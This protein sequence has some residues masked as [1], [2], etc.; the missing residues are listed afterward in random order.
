M[1]RY[2]ALEEIDSILLSGA[3]AALVGCLEDD[4]LECK[5]A[6]YDLDVER[7]KM[8]LAKDVSALANSD[9]GIVLIGV[10][11]E[12]DPTYKSDIIR[13]VSCFT[14]DLVDLGRYRD[15]I[16]DWVI[17]SIPGL[18]FEWHADST[19]RNEGI[20]SIRVPKEACSDRP[21]VVAKAVGDVGGTLGSYLGYFERTRETV[22]PIK[23]AELRDRLRDGRRFSELDRRLGNIEETVGKLAAGQSAQEPPFTAEAVFRR[24]ERARAQAGL[25]GAPCLSFA[26]WPLQPIE[27]PN[28]FGSHQV[29]VV[30]VLEY[31]P[32]LREAGFNI[33]TRRPSDI[34][35]ARL[36]RCLLP[37]RVLEV[38]RDGPVICVLPGGDWHLCWGMRSSEHPG[39]WI[40][41]LALAET[42]YLLCDWASKI[43][44]YARPLPDA[45]RVRLMLSDMTT[46]G[47][48]VSLSPY[49]PDNIN[50]YGHRRSAP[51][52]QSGQH[53]EIEVERATARPGVTAHRLLADLYAW[54]GFNT[55]QMP[56]ASTD[57]QEAVIDP[58]QIVQPRFP[59][60]SIR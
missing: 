11:T 35:E 30:H 52:G 33:G 4:H 40:N 49:G 48:P 14:R 58:A 2:I 38:W 16:S 43:Y 1:P 41:P 13:R 51:A 60:P 24:V 59:P 26:A 7:T 9:G 6:P 32:Y 20:V 29:P 15:V 50:Q 46:D 27:F 8:E 37:G 55:A 44:E 25:E 19:S 18:R 56:Y 57:D 34:V 17:P 3:F 21:F 42:V 23:P 47:E 28:L 36:R 45:F 53:F 10:H 31:P 22:A 5:A 54:F 39:L 12:R